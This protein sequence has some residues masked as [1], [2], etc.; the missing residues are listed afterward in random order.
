[1]A[2]PILFRDDHGCK[3]FVGKTCVV[4]AG[5]M[6]I[7]LAIC[8]RLLSEGC[9]SLYLCSRK[10]NNVDE[11]VKELSEKY[12]AS[13]VFGKTCNVSKPG[14]LEDFVLAVSKQFN[15]RV[16]CVVSNVGLVCFVWVIFSKRV[17]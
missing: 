12:G 5:T 17:F 2:D 11:A 10:Q 6:G 4:T 1:M 9:D 3:R 14:E 15:G 7:G 16:D 13:R 8:H